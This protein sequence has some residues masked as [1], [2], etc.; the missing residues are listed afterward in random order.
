[1]SRLRR[2]VLDQLGD[3]RVAG[4]RLRD[5]EVQSADPHGPDRSLV[6]L[7]E[8]R[9]AAPIRAPDGEAAQSLRQRSASTPSAA[10]AV[11][12]SGTGPASVSA[13]FRPAATATV[14]RSVLSTAV[15]AALPDPVPGSSASL[16]AAATAWPAASW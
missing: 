8:P 6:M 12:A 10:L 16:A 15:P 3:A 11:G 14:P 2:L 7:Q 13:G 4:C 5:Y 9:A 1:M